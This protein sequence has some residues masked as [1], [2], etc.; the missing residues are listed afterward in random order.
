MELLIQEL[1]RFLPAGQVLTLLL[2]VWIL[3]K[4]NKTNGSIIELQTWRHGH[5]KEDDARFKQMDNYINRH[6]NG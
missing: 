2:L 1:M 4:V 3:I 6:N 5:I